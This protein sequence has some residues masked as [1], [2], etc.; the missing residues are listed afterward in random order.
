MRKKKKILKKILKKEKEILNHHQSAYEQN[1]AN[2]RKRLEDLYN[3]TPDFRTEY[4]PKVVTNTYHNSGVF[5][6]GSSS[7][8]VN[9]VVNEEIT[10]DQRDLK[11]DLSNQMAA[12]DKRMF[13][14]NLERKNQL[15]SI[16]NQKQNMTD[17][18]EARRNQIR[19]AKLKDKNAQRL[20]FRN[21][22]I[23]VEK[24]IEFID[25][26]KIN[27]ALQI[28]KLRE[29]SGGI[30]AKIDKKTDEINIMEAPDSAFKRSQEKAINKF[31]EQEKIILHIQRTS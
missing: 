16:E 20:F 13:N 30:Q 24:E 14:F 27:V 22:I 10:H 7:K 19:D 29:K 4:R 9:S 8:T 21:L 31:K 3:N 2:N 23:E 11:K 17:M 5:G 15:K 28:T 1:I 12:L 6:I 25:R 26:E 18:V